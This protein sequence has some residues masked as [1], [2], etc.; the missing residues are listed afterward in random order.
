MKKLLTI[1]LA[2]V[3]AVA[4]LGLVACKQDE[5]TGDGS[6]CGTYK[7]SSV[8]YEGNEITIGSQEADSLGFTAD[9]VVLTIN[10]DGTATLVNIAVADGYASGTWTREGN[11]FIMTVDTESQI[12]AISNNTITIIGDGEVI[13]LTKVV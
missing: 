6:I 13:I 4:C 8:I 5:P 12:F 9:T 7:L 10:S 1:I 11:D 3:L 2:V